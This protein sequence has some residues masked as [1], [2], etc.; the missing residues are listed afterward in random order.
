MDDKVA[1]F[2]ARFI[3]VLFWINFKNIIAHLETNWF[4]FWGDVFARIF[5]MTECFI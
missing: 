5:N 2:V 4:Y 3:E 1:F